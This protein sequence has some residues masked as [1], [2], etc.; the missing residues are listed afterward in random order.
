MGAKEPGTAREEA[1]RLVATL[2]ATVRMAATNPAATPLGPLGGLVAG[3][4]GHNDAPGA[5][6][7]GARSGF[8]TGGAECCVCPVCRGIAALRDPSP[9][10]AERLATGTGDLAAGL[11]SFLR[12][13]APAESVVAPTSGPAAGATTDP[14][15][16][17]VWREATRTGHDSQPAPE[18]DVWAAATRADDVA[19]PAAAPVDA[20]GSVTPAA[21]RA[22][23]ER[24]VVPVSRVPEGE[25]A[26]GDEAAPD[27]RTVPG[28]RQDAPGDE[29]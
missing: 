16:D 9:E 25:P 13:F 7:G 23:T 1:E 22:S 2:L 24:R 8:A 29:A 20:A 15:D 27:G 21:R 19:V 4:L 18:R 11:A 6:P 28:A 17:H 26:P 3:V 14:F 12:A 10:F 5:T